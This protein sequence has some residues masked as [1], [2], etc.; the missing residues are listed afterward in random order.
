MSSTRIRDTRLMLRLAM[1]ALTTFAV[2]TARTAAAQEQADTTHPSFTA[3]AR[4]PVDR[5]FAWALGI[6]IPGAGHVYAGE[7]MRGIVFGATAVTGAVMAFRGAQGAT[8][9]AGSLLWLGAWSA[10]LFDLPRALR[11]HE[12]RPEVALGAVRRG[13]VVAISFPSP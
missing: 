10:S 12:D 11:E 4:K 2:I 9:E 13:I 5:T 3:Q 6:A 1:T 8:S 7:T